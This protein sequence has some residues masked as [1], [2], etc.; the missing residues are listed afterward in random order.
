MTIIWRP[1]AEEQFRAAIRFLAERDEAVA[2][3]MASAVE[4]A[5]QILELRP[6][7]ARK[8]QYPGFSAWSLTKWKKIIIFREI[9]D[10]IE[11]A[12]LLDTRQLPPKAVRRRP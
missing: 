10:G 5:T 9:P 2:G 6:Q 4:A 7:V 8:S 12:T 1:Q 11:I 3:E